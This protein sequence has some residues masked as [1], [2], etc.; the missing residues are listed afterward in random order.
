MKKALLM[1]LVQSLLE[2]LTPE[3]L[4]AA[5][6]KLLDFAEDKVADS[7]TKIDDTIVLP[8]CAMIRESFNIPD[9]D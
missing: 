7:E 8:I 2:S 5:A 3:M 4:K 6:D 9:N 1:M